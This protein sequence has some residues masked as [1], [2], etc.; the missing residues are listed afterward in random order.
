[1][2]KPDI[3]KIL[4]TIDKFTAIDTPFTAYDITKTLRHEGFLTKHQD[5]KDAFSDSFS[6]PW[7]YAKTL[8]PTLGAWVYHP[9][10]M[11]VTEYDP[12]AVADFY[13]GNKNTAQPIKSPNTSSGVVNKGGRYCVPSAYVKQA[14]L[15]PNN[16]VSVIVE[17]GKIIIDPNNT[18]GR[19]LMV[20][21]YYNIRIQ[22][23]DFEQA[24]NNIPSKVNISLKSGSIEITD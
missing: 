4:S 6:L 9:D 7:D 17:N 24:F 15:K 8:H 1:M 2:N 13:I 19:I 5:V 12:Q 22:K 23:K 11:A 14:L 16:T 20:D 21:C 3:N 10:S 18:G